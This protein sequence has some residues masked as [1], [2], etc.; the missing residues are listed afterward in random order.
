MG[1]T[2][3]GQCC[4]LFC[5]RRAWRRSDT[6]CRCIV[7]LY[8][9]CALPSKASHGTVSPLRCSALRCGTVPLQCCAK[10]C[11]ALRYPA[12]PLLRVI[13]LGYAFAMPCV[14]VRDRSMLCHCCAL[15]CGA[16][17]RRALPWLCHAWRMRC[18][19]VRR[20]SGAWPCLRDA[21]LSV[22]LPLLCCAPHCLCH[23]SP[24]A[25]SLRLCYVSPRAA[26]LRLCPGESPP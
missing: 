21:M 7:L 4:A 1:C 26:S 5:L 6:P 25:A 22:A 24:R 16:I 2:I 8:L 14:A 11:C 9:C 10:L 19:A 17:P 3:A 15:R 23:V 13:E 18:Y 12:L 20:H